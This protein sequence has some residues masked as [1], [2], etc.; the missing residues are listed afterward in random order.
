MT[1]PQLT[2]DHFRDATAICRA[3]LHHDE[4]GLISL[5]N[6]CDPAMTFQALVRLHLGALYTLAPDVELIDHFLTSYCEEM[7]RLEGLQ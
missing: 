2:V 6:A 5:V 4:A 1:T 3:T 7:T